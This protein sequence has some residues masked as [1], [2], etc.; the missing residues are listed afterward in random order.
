[1]TDAVSNSCSFV[2]AMKMSRGKAFPFTCHMELL[3][4]LHADILQRFKADTCRCNDCILGHRHF[5][6]IGS[7]LRNVA[8]PAPSWCVV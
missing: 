3:L 2:A 1:M 6:F 8:A 7:S 5:T 4:I